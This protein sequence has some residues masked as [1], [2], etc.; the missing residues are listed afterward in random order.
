M[1]IERIR[2]RLAELHPDVTAG[3]W[4]HAALWVP[5]GYAS[6][7]LY[8]EALPIVVIGALAGAVALVHRVLPAG[9]EV[10]AGGGA[11]VMGVNHAANGDCHLLV[12]EDGV[13]V[14]MGF[15]GVMFAWAVLRLLGP[16]SIHEASRLLL[17]GA[18][19][20]ELALSTVTPL[21]D[22]THAFRGTTGTAAA[23]GALVL[24]FTLV[25][26]KTPFGPPLLGSALVGVLG[27][28]AVTGGPCHGAATRA[29]VGTLVFTVLAVFLETRP[30]PFGYDDDRGGE[31]HWAADY[32]EH[33]PMSALRFTALDELPVPPRVPVRPRLRE[34]SERP[35][36]PRLPGTHRSQ[37]MSEPD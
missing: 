17:I 23:L 20:L 26:V 16:A 30:L 36:L 35:E 28:L 9:V 13:A 4:W 31:E 29:L 14:L 21:G 10:V 11:L 12:G 25:G 2:E 15:G 5:V 33:G 19:A 27:V 8:G 32:E 18:V 22:A 34:L 3:R 37:E 1:T 7:K 24:A 6:T